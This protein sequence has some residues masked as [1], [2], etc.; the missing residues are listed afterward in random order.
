VRIEIEASIES[1]TACFYLAVHRA[2]G[3]CVWTA[4][5]YQHL[6]GRYQP[7][8]T[9]FHIEPGRS[10]ISLRITQCPLNAGSYGLDVGIEPVPNVA[11]VGDYHDYFPRCRKF[12]IIRQ[13][14]LV[15]NKV[16]DSPSTWSIQSQ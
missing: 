11:T 6:D 10:R 14:S 1:K 5:N 12:S 2:D 3:L 9:P 8:S 13:D 7:V 15:L 4:T 16:C